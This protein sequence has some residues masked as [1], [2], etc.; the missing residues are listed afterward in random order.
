MNKLVKCSDTV[1]RTPSGKV[2]VRLHRSSRR[3]A[4]S[5][6]AQNPDTF[7]E[8]TRLAFELEATLP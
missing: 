5:F 6:T 1:Y 2:T 4:M 7:A 3:G 8:A